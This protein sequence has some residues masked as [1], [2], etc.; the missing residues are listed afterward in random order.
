MSNTLGDLLKLKEE[1]QILDCLLLHLLQSSTGVR[2]ARL[3]ASRGSITR[4]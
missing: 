1:L 4:L 3:L 2:G